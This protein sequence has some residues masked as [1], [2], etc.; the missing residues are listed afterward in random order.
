MP[1]LGPLFCPFELIYT[2]IIGLRKSSCCKKEKEAC[3]D[4]SAY[5]TGKFELFEKDSFNIFLS[6]E[7]EEREAHVDT[8]IHHVD[9]KIQNIEDK[10][11][12]IKNSIDESK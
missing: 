2:V 5:F 4:Y 8:K 10:M 9:T 3:E 7:A 12:E 6:K 11:V 1:G